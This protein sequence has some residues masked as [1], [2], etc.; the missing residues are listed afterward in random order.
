M[1]LRSRS[2][3]AALQGLADGTALPHEQLAL[4]DARAAIGLVSH[5]GFAS[6]AIAGGVSLRNDELTELIACAHDHGMGVAV[7]TGGML[8]AHEA[9]LAML[10]AGDT[11]HVGVDCFDAGRDGLGAVL[12]SAQAMS[13]WSDAGVALTVGCGVFKG[14]L[15]DVER[16]TESL[17]DRGV[18]AVSFRTIERSETSA[19][20]MADQILDA[21]ERHLLYVMT[22]LLDRRLGTRI[23]VR[24]DLLHKDRLRVAPW[25]IYGGEPGPGPASPACE[26][27]VLVLEPD[28]MLV[29]VCHGFDRRFALG[30]MR[31]VCHDPRGAWQEFARTAMPHLKLM[32]AALL[33]QLREDDLTTAVNPAELLSEAAR[34]WPVP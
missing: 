25:L 17:A 26:L 34:G 30:D 12:A 28:G 18:G 4:P 32:G 22:H 33:A 3:V 14:N 1:H 10:R 8:P 20:Q 5:W 21:D 2:K 9:A 13:R 24:C 15:H 27:G 11:V 29:P 6:M 31:S 19:P 7:S 23:R 16:L